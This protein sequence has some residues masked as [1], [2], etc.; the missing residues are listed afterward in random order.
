MS[1]DIAHHDR[2]RKEAT[3]YTQYL[4]NRHPSEEIIERYA[5]ANRKLA[6]DS[7]IGP[8][9]S[10][11]RFSLAHPWSVPFLDAAAGILDP[12]SQFRKKIYTMAA[13][14]EASTE[15]TDEFFPTTSSAVSLIIKLTAYVLAAGVKI[16]LGIPVF[17]YVRR[18]KNV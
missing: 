14:L 8:D 3:L 1:Q 18:L 13:V 15:Y 5:H 9:A 7:D 12:E 6:I 17:L 10:I 11:V 2:L 16:M 4:I